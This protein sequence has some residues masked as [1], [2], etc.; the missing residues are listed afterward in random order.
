MA[1]AITASPI[2]RNAGPGTGVA[3]GGGVSV[4]TGVGAA[5]VSANRKVENPFGEA[6]SKV[7]V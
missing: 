4:T 6:I 2:S 5:A 1:P 7:T 3:D